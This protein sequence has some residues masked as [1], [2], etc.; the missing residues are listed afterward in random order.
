MQRKA[1]GQL[2][3]MVSHLLKSSLCHSLH[4]ARTG[5]QSSKSDEEACSKLWDVYVG[6]A[7]RYD[8]SLLEGWKKDMDGMLLFVSLLFFYVYT[9]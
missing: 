7:K 1:S 6:E 8:M 5:S 9:I 4:S 3:T 2:R